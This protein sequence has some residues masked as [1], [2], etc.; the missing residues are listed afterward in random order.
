M[1][2][3]FI[4]KPCVIFTPQISLFWSWNY[5]K[6]TFNW[7]KTVT[8]KNKTGFSNDAFMYDNKRNKWIIKKLIFPSHNIINDATISNTN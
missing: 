5:N 7:S 1:K 8:N 2:A 4:K 3:R 6:F